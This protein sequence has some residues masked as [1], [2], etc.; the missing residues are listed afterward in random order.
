MK[1]R[2]E[3][4]KEATAKYL[5]KQISAINQ[6]INHGSM[7]EPDVDLVIQ[8]QNGPISIPIKDPHRIKAREAMKRYRSLGHQ[9]AYKEQ[10]SKKRRNAWLK[11]QEQEDKGT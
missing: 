9:I 8:T 11:R 7:S 5:R 10:L 2:L 3:I 4:I 6:S 1:T